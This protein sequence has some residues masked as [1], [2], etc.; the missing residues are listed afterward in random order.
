M[1]IALPA[2]TC[3]NCVIPWSAELDQF[4]DAPFRPAP[5]SLKVSIENIY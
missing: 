4:P 1:P 2:Q 3:E 5:L